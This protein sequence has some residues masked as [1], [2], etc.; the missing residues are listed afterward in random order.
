[1]A[2]SELESRTKF[3]FCLTNSFVDEKPL[4][5]CFLVSEAVKAAHQTD[6]SSDLIFRKALAKK[7]E[8]IYIY[9]NVEKLVVNW[10][11]NSLS[12]NFFYLIIASVLKN[13]STIPSLKC[14]Y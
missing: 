12:V 8:R 14:L 5:Q 7:K 1:M 3:V 2:N 13:S 6:M 11:R 10:N 4:F 9:F